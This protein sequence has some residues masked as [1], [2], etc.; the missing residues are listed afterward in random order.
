VDEADSPT[1]EERR[2]LAEEARRERLLRSISDMD[3][4]AVAARW[5]H[6]THPA[7]FDDFRLRIVMETGLF[8]TYARPFTEGRGNP[9]LPLAPTSGLTNDQRRIHAWA[10]ERR[11]K[12]AAHVDRDNFDRIV[13]PEDVTVT[14]ADRGQSVLQAGGGERYRT[15]SR[16]DLLALAELAEHLAARYRA[17]VFPE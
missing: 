7:G 6:E 10:I 16:D 4:A 12:S 13:I 17:E 8:V 1:P 11:K 9:P 5:L 2:A 14:D 15:P 3:D